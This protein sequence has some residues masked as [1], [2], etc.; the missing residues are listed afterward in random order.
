LFGEDVVFCERAKNAGYQLYIDTAIHAKHLKV[1]PI[2]RARLPAQGGRAS[3][4]R[5]G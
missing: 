3:A 2:L 4:R 5:A 1:N